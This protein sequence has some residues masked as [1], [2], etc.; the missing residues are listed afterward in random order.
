L[1]ARG[2]L[3]VSG[4]GV[5]NDAAT[6]AQLS[7]GNYAKTHYRLQGLDI[8]IETHK[9][10]LRTGIGADG[11]RWTVEMPADYGYIRRTIGADDEQLDCYVGPHPDSPM[12]WIVEQGHL[13]TGAFDEEKAMLGFR[14]RQEAL[15]VYVLG[16][17]DGRGAQRILGVREM[18][19]A[20]FKA[21]A[22]ATA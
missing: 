11:A 2:K 12:V 5:R 8:T 22:F 9:G 14:T 18:E 15:N 1:T 10:A 19:M 3:W 20:E 21:E 6:P 4:K 7:A 17:S 13:E 16:F